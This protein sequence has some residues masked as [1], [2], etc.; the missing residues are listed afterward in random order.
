MKK[1]LLLCLCCLMGTGVAYAQTNTQISADSVAY[2]LQRKKINSMLDGRKLRFGQ[3]SQSLNE[4][5]GIFGLQ[6]KSDIRRSND[7]LM[8][9]V[10]TDDNIY[11]EL[12]ILLEYRAFQ[13][14]QIQNHSKEAESINL[15]Y[16]STINKLRQQN[17]LLKADAQ[18]AIE[19]K[20]NGQRI[21]ILIIVLMFASIL[22]L[23]NKKSK[24]K[25]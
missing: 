8:D 14:R 18:K 15:G 7:I 5:T 6:T 24:V 4:H 23:I 10:K 9:I 11:K 20:E 3:Y 21:Y 25:V 22:F 2:Q 12:K 13:Q 19:Q 17:V 16:M 1:I